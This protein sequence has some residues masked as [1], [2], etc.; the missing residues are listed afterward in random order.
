LNVLHVY[1]DADACAVKQEVYRVAERYGLEVTLVANSW[2]RVPNASWLKLVVVEKGAD[3]ADDWIAENA[4]PDDIVVTDDIPL[5]A[6]SLDKGARCLGQR[7][8][9]FTESS[10]GDALASRQLLNQ[11]RDQGVMTG[12]PPAFSQK[13]RSQFLQSLDQMVNTIKREA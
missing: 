3:A 2:M 4:E 8:R 7:G 1:V 6:R 13:D 9:P 12:G 10:I 5:A 11:L